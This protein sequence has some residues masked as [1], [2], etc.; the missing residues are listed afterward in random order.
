[1]TDEKGDWAIIGPEGNHSKIRNFL[2]YLWI[3]RTMDP[4]FDIYKPGYTEFVAFGNFS[5]WPCISKEQNLEGIILM[6]PGNTKEKR[7]KFFEK[8]G[9]E[10]P[11]C[12]VNNPEK[13]LRDLNFAF[14]YPNNM[15]TLSHIWC[16]ENKIRPYWVYTVVGLRKAKTREE[17]IKAMNNLV[18]DERLIL[19][20]KMGSEERERLFGSA[21]RD[22]K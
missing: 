22:K 20:L 15:I 13:K 16:R 9:L 6:R 3:F 12:P 5:A 2:Q 21:G 18:S 1:M 11:F 8:L 17:R 19:A 7:K 14:E 4:T 10:V